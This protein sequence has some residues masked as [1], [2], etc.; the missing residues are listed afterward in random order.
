MYSDKY[1]TSLQVLKPFLKDLPGRWKQFCKK[2]AIFP[3]K[4]KLVT[5][6]RITEYDRPQV[7][8]YQASKVFK[9][10]LSKF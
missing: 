8:C 10:S 9:L 2:K 5:F 4:N 3:T 6:S 1:W 7:T